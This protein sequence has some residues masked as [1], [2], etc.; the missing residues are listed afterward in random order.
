MGLMSLPPM[1][2]TTTTTQL[3]TVVCSGTWTITVTVPIAPT[4]MGLAAALGPHDVA[5][6]P[7]LIPR[8]TLR[9]VV[10]LVNVPQE[11]S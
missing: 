8:E 1:P 6:P 3:V 10:G 9:G 7:T 2:T 5:L 4:S 11:E